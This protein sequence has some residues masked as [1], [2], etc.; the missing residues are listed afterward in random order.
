MSL[1]P[2]PVCTD[3]RRNK[4]PKV[5][6]PQAKAHP[7]GKSTNSTELP[8]ISCGEVRVMYL[9]KKKTHTYVHFKHWEAQELD[10]R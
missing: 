1:K 8:G 3:P 5:S 2:W 7:V 10:T 4:A 9:Q 6:H